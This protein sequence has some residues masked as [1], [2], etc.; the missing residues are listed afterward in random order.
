MT[1]KKYTKGEGKTE[2]LR[3]DEAVVLN[4]HF[5]RTGKRQLSEFSEDELSA[6][7]ADLDEV[8]EPS[9]EAVDSDD[10]PE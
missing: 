2:V 3:G 1:M 6:F 4:E 5:Q 7:N 10:Q 9:E 8:S